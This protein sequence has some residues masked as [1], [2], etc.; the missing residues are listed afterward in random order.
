MTF[1]MD[2]DPAAPALR[3]ERS[4]FSLTAGG[5]FYR[6]L[7]RLH[8]RTSDTMVRSWWIAFLIWVPLA[9]G[10][11]VGVLLGSPIDPMLFDLSL[12]TRLLFALPILLSS[13][14]L[15]EQTAKSAMTSFS[16]CQ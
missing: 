2:G 1:A 8:L 11:G 14:L 3:R 16:T 10:E 13:E 4:S 5:P 6:L 9:I 12:H 7:T 15:Q